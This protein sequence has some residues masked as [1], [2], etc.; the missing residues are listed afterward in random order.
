MESGGGQVAIHSLLIEFPHDLPAKT[1]VRGA[2]CPESALGH[3]LVAGDV[4]VFVSHMPPVTS[5]IG[6][7][8]R[9]LHGKIKG[10]S[11]AS[12]GPLAAGGWVQELSGLRDLFLPELRNPC[13]LLC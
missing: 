5:Y 2:D 12:R 9:M 10:H 7:V 6:I 3:G 11:I 4:I 1:G 8:R 13:M